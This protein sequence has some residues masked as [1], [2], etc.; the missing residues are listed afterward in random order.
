M[1]RLTIV[2]MI[3]VLFSLA[4]GEAAAHAS[5]DHAEPGAGKTVATAPHE[6]TL[7][8]TEKLEPAFST[9]TVIDAAGERVDAGKSRVSGDTMVISLRQIGS[10]AYQVKWHALSADSHATDG[11]FSFKVG[12]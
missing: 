4:S 10:G 1:R 2:G 7:W 6:V 5:L 11:S 8:F 3:P 9:V 12:P